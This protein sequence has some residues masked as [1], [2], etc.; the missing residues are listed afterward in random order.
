MRKSNGGPVNRSECLDMIEIAHVQGPVE[1]FVVAN[2]AER[3]YEHTVDLFVD[4][5]VLFDGR[6]ADIVAVVVFLLCSSS[7]LLLLP[8]FWL[9]C[10]AWL[11]FLEPFTL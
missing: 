2:V 5:V 1:L 11:E 7:L 4:Y 8:L 6:R 9:A 3:R 10:F